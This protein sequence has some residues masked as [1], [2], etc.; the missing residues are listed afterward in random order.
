[1]FW[2][3][4]YSFYVELSL[5]FLNMLLK[6]NFFLPTISIVFMVNQTTKLSCPADVYRYDH[7]LQNH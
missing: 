7:E 1:M 2:N 3:Q 5:W 4:S 6:R